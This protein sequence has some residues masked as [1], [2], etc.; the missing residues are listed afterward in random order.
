[1]EQGCKKTEKERTKEQ[2]CVLLHEKETYCGAHI[3]P[4]SHHSGKES[5]GKK[6]KEEEKGRKRR[7][8]KKGKEGR[9]RERERR[10]K[11]EKNERERQEEKN[12]RI[13]NPFLT[14]SRVHK[15]GKLH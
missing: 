6:D 3:S 1:M 8:R 12:E 7:E 10:R 5:K 11:K 9:E 13:Q 4:A 15:T 2:K 14:G